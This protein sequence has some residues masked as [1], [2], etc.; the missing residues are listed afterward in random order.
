[1]DGDTTEEEG[2]AQRKSA[3]PV[4]SAIQVRGHIVFRI[5]ESP[6]GRRAG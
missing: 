4:I 2:N 1:V 6:L 3:K 5:A